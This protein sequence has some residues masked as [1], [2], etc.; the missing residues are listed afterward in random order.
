MRGY[1]ELDE[2]LEK[3][4]R[5]FTPSP[6]ERALVKATISE[7]VDRLKSALADLQLPAEPTPVGSAV[8]DTWL[9]GKADIDIFL[10]FPPDY[11]I[12]KLGPATL[13]AAERAFGGYRLRYA[14]HPYAVVELNGFEIDV[15]PAYKISSCRELRSP[16]DRTPLHNQFLLKRLNDDLRSEIR[17][18]KAFLRGIGAYGAELSVGGFSG[19]LAEL[20]ILRFGSFLSLMRSACDWRPPVTLTLE[21]EPPEWVAESESPLILVDPVDPRRNVASAVT[22]TQFNRF[23]VACSAL[24]KNPSKDFFTEKTL[25]PVSRRELTRMVEERGTTLLLVLYDGLAEPPD[26][27]WSQAISGASRLRRALEDA[28]FG[29]LQAEGWTDEVSRVALVLEVE[30]ETL[31]RVEKRVGPEVGGPG[32]VGFL[33][34]H[35]RAEDTLSGPYIEG[36]RWV[37]F[38]ARKVTSLREAV[39]ELT[40][41]VKSILPKLLREA[42]PKILLQHDA[43]FPGWDDLL[44]FLGEFL[45]RRRDFFAERL[46]PPED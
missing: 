5:E 18:L 24:L 28:G 36:P 17:L 37:A 9:P 26:T 12:D 30:R 23:R 35:L 41:S 29:P 11:P 42:K 38:K 39:E 33:R 14:S 34:K 13:A 46:V 27:L 40:S 6:E 45:R 32:E 2:L 31:P 15:V 22:E 21:G 8:R 10:L 3:L 7:A 20:L 19:Y 16:V 44:P 43:E 1:S 25:P 4:R